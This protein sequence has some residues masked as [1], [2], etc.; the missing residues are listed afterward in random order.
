LDYSEELWI[1]AHDEDEQN[2]NL[3]NHVWDDNGLDIP[4][5]YLNTLLRYLGQ[6]DPF[7]HQDEGLT[8]QRMTAQQSVSVALQLSR[9]QRSTTPHKSGRLSKACKSSTL[10]KP[11]CSS[12]SLIAL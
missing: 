7:Y 3:A 5:T 8:S 12:P 9:T 10:K 1:A 6:Y 2:A 4:E 11:R